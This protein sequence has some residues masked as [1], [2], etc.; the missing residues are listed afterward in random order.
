MEFKQGFL[1]GLGIISAIII[2]LAF[3]GNPGNLSAGMTTCTN[4]SERTITVTGSGYVYSV[5]DQ[6]IISVGVVTE[7]TTST[8]AMAQNADKMDAVIKAVKAKGIPEKDIQTKRVSVQPVYNYFVQPN[9]SADK[10]QIVGYT[11]TNTVTITV[12]DTAKTGPVIDAA[13]AS[14]S[15]KINGVSFMLSDEKAKTLYKEA[16]EK[17]VIE[18][19]D[20]AKTIA[21]AADIQGMKLK[22]ITESGYYYPQPY[23][24]SF[25]GYAM[26]K[27]AAAPTPIS[28][29][30]EKVTATVTMVY[31][32]G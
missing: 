4:E 25:A 15:N 2:V 23:Y 21:S 7:A 11:A 28:P 12:R 19:K 31:T 6:A 20:K 29:G 1:L 10:P 5:P 9:G 24:D 32:F 13:Y 17:A 14:G 26:E 30:E 16:L 22:T 18:G 27:S 3:I 8:D